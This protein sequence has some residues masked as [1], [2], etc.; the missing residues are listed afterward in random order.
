M[1]QE[2]PLWGIST[3]LACQEMELDL[4][5]RSLLK[6]SPEVIEL[7][8]GTTAPNYAQ[9]QELLTIQ[10]G[11]GLQY[12]IHSAE[13][14]RPRD[15]LKG[16]AE[17]FRAKNK[18][19]V[20]LAQKINPLWIVQHPPITPHGNILVEEYL[21]FMKL[22]GEFKQPVLLE[23]GVIRRDRN[24]Q[25]AQEV[26]IGRDPKELALYINQPVIGVVADVPKMSRM[27]ELPHQGRRSKD[28]IQEY[29]RRSKEYFATIYEMHVTGVDFWAEDLEF[30]KY[31]LDQARE[32]E[33]HPEVVMIEST[34]TRLPMVVDLVT[35]SVKNW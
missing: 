1:S 27:R 34:A 2:K 13:S 25:L 35:D 4:A 31:A 12:T 24:T 28:D 16:G 3:G 33:I 18:A 30:D 29:F 19:T 20:D 32:Q 9:V 10:R 5:V 22:I 7:C 26:E 8:P 11:E 15:L 6:H 23:T 17:W 21:E 14:F